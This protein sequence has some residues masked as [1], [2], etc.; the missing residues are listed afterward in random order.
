MTE[1]ARPTLQTRV[2]TLLDP[3]REE[4]SCALVV[5][6]TLYEALWDPTGR[7]HRIH[8]GA[9]GRVA[10]LEPSP[11]PA[12]DVPDPLAE[13]LPGGRELPEDEPFYLHRELRQVQIQQMLRTDL[14]RAEFEL[15]HREAVA[16]TRPAFWDWD[17]A[18]AAGGAP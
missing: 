13:V 6:P 15:E 12:I 18:E 14:A 7:G 10:D 9:I 1:Q 16:L 2:R 11:P 17:W 3:A 4:T 8:A 5:G